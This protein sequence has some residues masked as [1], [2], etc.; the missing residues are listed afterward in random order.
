MTHADVILFDIDG[1]LV[2]STYHHAMCW[3]RAFARTG[4]TVPVWKLHR[5]IGMGGDRLVAHVAGDEVEAEHGDQVRDRWAEEYAQVVDDVQT[6]PG[7][8]DLVRKL[9]A[10][11]TIALASSGE[12]KFSEAALRKLGV[13]DVVDVMTSSNDAED[14]KPEADILTVTLERVGDVERSVL[15]GDTPYDVEAAARI[16]LRTVAVLT[17]GFGRAEL[18]SAGAALVVEELTELDDLDWSELLTAPAL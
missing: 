1:T 14:S 11:Y 9:A 16:G 15:V 12:A 17:G 18:E 2:D 3:H 5:A 7:A 8:S 13:G 10:D 6:L 4:I